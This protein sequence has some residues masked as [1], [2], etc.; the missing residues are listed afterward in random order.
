M[1]KTAWTIVCIIGAIA[2]AAIALASAVIGGCNSM[3]ELANGGSA[4]MKCHWTFVAD[5]FIGVAG[6]V[7]A[8]MGITCK[9]QTGRRMV[10]VSVI[11]IA[12]IAACMPMTFGIGLCAKAGMQCQATALAVWVL[13]AVAAI[14]GIVQIAKS[15]PAAADLPKRSI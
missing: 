9:E 5:T 1:R 8:L 10:G 7:I 11:M 15:N 3:V 13:C 14:V 12:L 4:P 6:A 2:F